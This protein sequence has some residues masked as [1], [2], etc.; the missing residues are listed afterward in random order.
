MPLW[1][2]LNAT[3]PGRLW[4]L[5]RWKPTAPARLRA[6]QL[7]RLLGLP[8]RMAIDEFLKEHGVEMEY[9]LEDLERD[10][11]THRRLGL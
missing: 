2:F 3:L 11:D 5:W 7:R 9:G 4:K 10:R 8:T 6:A 1:V